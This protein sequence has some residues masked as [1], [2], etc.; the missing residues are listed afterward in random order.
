MMFMCHKL[1]LSPIL[2]MCVCMHVCMY[3]G[4]FNLSVASKVLSDWL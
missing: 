3:G 2:C 1:I 4:N